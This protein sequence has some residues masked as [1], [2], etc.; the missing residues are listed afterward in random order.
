MAKPKK[1]LSTVERWM[2]KPGFK[3]A[4]KREYKEFLLSELVLA[5]MAE[6]T[7]SVRDWPTNWAYP[8]P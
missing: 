6:D 8:K 2:K 1:L 7:K 3:E 4:F 5:L